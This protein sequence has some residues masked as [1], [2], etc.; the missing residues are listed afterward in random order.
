MPKFSQQDHRF[1]AQALQ[2]ARKG[3]F[4]THP[5]PRVG[6]VVVKDGVVLA[7]GWHHKAGEPHAEAHAIASAGTNLSGASVYV[8]LEPCS[9]QG[10]TPP[11]SQALVDARVA[12][13]VIAA[14]DPNP[15]VNGAGIKQLEQAGIRVETG[16]NEA[17][18]RELNKGFYSLHER[19]R[20]WVRLKT[21][22]SLDGRT[23]MA[24]GESQWITGAA[25]RVDGQ[26]LRAQSAALVSG[27]NTVLADDPRLTVRLDG[28]DRQPARIILD[29]SLRTPADARILGQDG[30]VMIFTILDPSVDAAK[31][32]IDQGAIV[33][34]VEQDKGRPSLPSVLM[35]LA[36]MNI[37]ELHVEAGRILT[38]AFIQAGLADELVIYLAPKLLGDTARGMLSLPGLDQLG[39]H[40]RIEWSDQR[41]IGDDLRLIL[42][43][44]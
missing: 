17:A 11:C 38:G 41:M 42:R 22:A 37:N 25:A 6:C 40:H 10:R 16:L 15:R 29:S 2:L 23:A 28:V 4:T 3:L 30:Q 8:T 39:Q 5:N 44:K 9:H 12:R 24:S 31:R 14:S 7:Q 26:R 20:P 33:I 21:A 43:M 36:G 27:V 13:V 34:Q 35:L 1:M 32:L 19:G 18:A